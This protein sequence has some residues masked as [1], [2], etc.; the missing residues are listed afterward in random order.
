MKHE[1]ARESH[2]KSQKMLLDLQSGIEHLCGK[3]NEI[4]L[5]GAGV[6]KNI[7]TINQE[8]LVEGLEQARQKL[9]LLYKELKKDPELFEEAMS[10]VQGGGLGGNQS[11]MFK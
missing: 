2:G 9:K 4:R 5:E 6:E 8:N 10:N 11:K 3:L 1:K 7:E